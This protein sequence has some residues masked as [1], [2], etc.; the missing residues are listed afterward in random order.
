MSPWPADWLPTGNNWVGDL[1]VAGTVEVQ[2]DAGV[3]GFELRKGGRQFDCRIDVATGRAAL[4]ISGEDV[5]TRRPTAATAV[6][7]RGSH[8]ILFSNCDNEL[9]LW[10]DGQVVAFDPVQ[11]NSRDHPTAYAD[12]GNHQPREDEENDLVPVG[13]GSA[14]T[15]LRI[16]HLRILR[17]IYYIADKWPAVNRVIEDSPEGVMFQLERDQFFVLGDNSSNSSDARLW[18]PKHYVQRDLLIGKASFL[19][20]PHSWNEIPTPW[21]NVPCPCFPSFRRMGP[22]R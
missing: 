6:R 1:A 13:V 5:R 15:R 9:Q 11:G 2:S 8:D 16:A 14:G 7:G 22:I 19:Y 18:G 20:W 10:V 4:S 17:N 21:G 12:L 3:V